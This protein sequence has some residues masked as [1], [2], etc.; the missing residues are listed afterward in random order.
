V[1]RVV[2]IAAVLLLALAASGV[3][4]WYL[5]F[6]VGNR[7]PERLAVDGLRAEASITWHVGGEAAVRLE[8]IRDLERVTGAVHALGRP[9]LLLLLRQAALGRLAEWYGREALP[10][11]HHVHRL[12]I[13]ATARAVFG[14]LDQPGQE[15]LRAYA[16]GVNA[17]L[18]DSRM[19]LAPAVAALD[20][21]PEPWEPW[22]ALAVERLVAWLAA[23]PATGSVGPGPAVL[24]FL[25]ARDALGELLGLGGL[26]HGAAW[27]MANQPPGIFV[28]LVYGTSGI[29]PVCVLSVHSPEGRLDLVTWLG[30]PTA[31]AGRSEERSWAVLPSGHAVVDSG[32]VAAEPVWI[33]L[34]L[35]DGSRDVAV[36]RTDGRHVAVSGD[37]RVLWPGIAPVSDLGAIADLAAGRPADFHLVDGLAMTTDHSRP[38][39][40]RTFGSRGTAHGT[41]VLVSSAAEARDLAASLDAVQELGAGRVLDDTGTAWAPA[42]SDLAE[43]LVAA[44]SATASAEREA[45]DFLSTWDGS[46]DGP[47]IGAALFDAMRQA[48]GSTGAQ[49]FLAGVDSLRRLFGTNA[50]SW[51][52][53]RTGPGLRYPGYLDSSP[54]PDFP[55]LPGR[56]A[57]VELPR[58]GHPTTASWGSALPYVNPPAP[59]A[60]E[61]FI[62][63]RDGGTVLY[64]RPFVPYDRLLGR[65]STTP[66]EREL[67][68]LA[69]RDLTGERTELVPNR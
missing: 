33:P 47:S 26:D 44:D 64:R 62:E 16:D 32:A 14:R 68:A 4:V 51:R 52:W 57:S 19:R 55:R 38:G 15:R 8:D 3:V 42:A 18:G 56:Y 22:H 25:E 21:D 48:P 36:R 34:R 49:A 5:A 63:D 29:P 43:Q 10:A 45:L 30:I 35:R 61:A 9:W 13:P 67:H 20:L 12:G 66:G 58:H 54:Y 17:A 39:P 1:I 31:W 11:D 50:R 53:E 59:A 60:W 65:F 2:R 23:T 24:G 28:R 46:F 6:R 37:L 69:G 40:A 27:Q 41:V 7:Q